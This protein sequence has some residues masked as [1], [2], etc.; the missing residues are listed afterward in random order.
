MAAWQ[1]A[2]TVL[3]VLACVLAL[4]LVVIGI[5]MLMR[6]AQ[7]MRRL[8]AV[9]RDI[10]VNLGPTLAEVREMMR[11]LNKASAGVADGVAHAGR[12][13]EAMGELSRT[14]HGA[15]KV[16]R[17]AFGPGVTV[18]AGLIAGLKAG[19]RVLLRQLFSRR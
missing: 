7:T 17:A 5:P 6:L 14:I 3:V 2:L 13:F 1:V 8:D 4:T 10:E 16:L 12:T 19:G 11:H 9:A 18:T 15:N